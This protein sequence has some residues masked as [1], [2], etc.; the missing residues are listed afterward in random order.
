MAAEEDSDSLAGKGLPAAEKPADSEPSESEP[1]GPSEP[2]EGP[3]SSPYRDDGPRPARVR[4]PQP[5][6]WQRSTYR[7]TAITAVM[8][9]L[10]V[11]YTQ[12]PYYLN[13]QFAPFRSV[14]TPAFVLW[15]ALG[16]F[17]VKAT[18]EKF[19]GTRYLMRDG[20]LHLLMLARSLERPRER[21]PGSEQR[22]RR[23]RKI[24]LGVGGAFSIVCAILRAS[25]VPIHVETA[26]GTAMGLPA[27]V[28]A[29]AAGLAVVLGLGF[30]VGAVYGW[31]FEYEGS[32]FWKLAVKPR[33]RTT[34]L[35][36]V[37]KGFYTPL[38]IGFFSGHANGIA[39]A[40]L[41][42]KHLPS[43]KFVLV[44]GY[45]WTQAMSWLE[46]MKARIPDLVP[47]GS[48]FSGLF[49]VSSWTR[50]D[51]SWGL[52]V[53]Y[54]IA[55]FVDCGWALIGYM[56]ESRW[57]GNK[58]RSVETTWL[59][60]AAALSCY[61]PYNNVLGTYLPLNDGPRLDIFKGENTQLVVRGLIVL[62]FFV[63]A[64]ATVAFGF[65]FSNL[66]NRG[67][68]S[69]GPYAVIRHPAYVCK[70]T[71]WWLEHLPTMTITKGFFLTLLCGVYA[72]RAWTEERHLSLDPE[73]RAYK[74][75]VPWVII[76]GV[77]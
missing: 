65:K 16:L 54:D 22:A 47:S 46:Q 7:W 28:L 48:D 39:E 73:Y 64:S 74:K 31:R 61:P 10:L 75:K 21:A 55:F 62:L 67:T 12:H 5:S 69:R 38:M 9:A 63:Y 35:G 15:L 27:G 43:L 2:S 71:A 57:L 53:A 42:H 26:F 45:P 23:A 11:L 33:V 1:S 40:W 6:I 72:L 29:F 60:W 30:G 24:G 56:L 14:Y 58:T 34:L 20:G 32:R 68:V 41:R 59:G 52:G 76:P 50:A 36:I 25:G 18:L 44:K 19:K 70:C 13:N 37:V 49:A 4:K 77:F 8:A 51:I 17:Y 3:S 66:T